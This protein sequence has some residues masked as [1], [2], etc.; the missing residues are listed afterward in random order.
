MSN[1]KRLDQECWLV[2]NVKFASGQRSCCQKRRMLLKAR[3]YSVLTTPFDMVNA[4][5]VIIDFRA[6]F[7]IK[8]Q[9]QASDT[10]RSLPSFSSAP[11]LL[12]AVPSERL[13][14]VYQQYWTILLHP[15]QAQ[16]YCSLLLTSVNN[17]SR[18]TLFNPVKQR[19]HNF[20]ACTAS[21]VSD[22]VVLD[23]IGH[24]K[25]PQWGVSW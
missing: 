1:V 13:G 2:D 23:V 12:R 8:I 14:Q 7:F 17:V 18:T 22:S 5:Y 21:N 20:Y 3:Y 16:Q 9:N 15:I 24:W 25:M 6:K 19:A 4:H 10:S 11:F